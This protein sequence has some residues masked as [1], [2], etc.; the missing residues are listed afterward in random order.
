VD[1]KILHALRAKINMS[2]VI[3]GDTWREW[4]V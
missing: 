2:T 1:E 4:V 3:N